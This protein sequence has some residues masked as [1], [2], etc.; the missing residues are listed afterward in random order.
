MSNNKDNNPNN[1]NELNIN[2]PEAVANGQYANL[3]IIGHSQ[4]EFVMDYVN[5]LP[6]M[7][8]GEVRT[9][10]IMA[11]I[12]AKRLLAALTENISKYENQFGEIQDT[13][14]SNIQFPININ[15]NT[16]QA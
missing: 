8:Q 7:P 14:N 4:S 11:P 15:A 12:H 2:L 10:V 6:G 16:G 13:H 1:G 5:L 9:R 3:A